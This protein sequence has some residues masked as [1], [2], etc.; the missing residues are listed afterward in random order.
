MR[1]PPDLAAQI[2]EAGIS[3]CPTVGR[4]PAVDFPM[5]AQAM[6]DKLGVRWGDRVEQ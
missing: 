4:L 5:Q 6:L 3:I 1:T 2:A